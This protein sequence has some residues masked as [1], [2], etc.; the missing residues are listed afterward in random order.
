MGD[1]A[2]GQ[3]VSKKLPAKQ[4]IPYVLLV[5]GAVAMAV[6]F[7]LPF[8]SAKGDYAEYLKQYGDRVYTA[9]AGLHNKD[10]VGLSLLTFLRIYIAGLQSGKLLGGMYLE[11]VICIT[12]MV[13]IA[14]SSLLILL[15][16]VL[17]KPIAAIVF[18]VLAVVAFY[19]L[20]WD[21]DDR[22]VLPSSQYGYGIAD[23]YP[24]SFV[25]V[26]AGAIWFMVSRHI[27]KTVHQQLANNTVNSA[28]VANGA[29]VAEP[30][31]PSKAE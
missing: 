19:A 3:Q 20:R 25:V 5:V 9:E 7:F 28:P 27:A 2:Q 12:L 10:V 17:K 15:F 6:S 21:F 31:A 26:V 16:G 1:I 18:S 11:A 14:V 29:A 22:G 30:V 23:I 24:I 13:V 8:A 4:L